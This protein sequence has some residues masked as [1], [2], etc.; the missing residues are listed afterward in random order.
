MESKATGKHIRTMLLNCA[1][2]MQDI[3]H[4][5]DFITLS[6]FTNEA[7]SDPSVMNLSFGFN[8]LTA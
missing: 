6:A 2:M 7:E 3:V 5:R 4:Y 1:E 8:L